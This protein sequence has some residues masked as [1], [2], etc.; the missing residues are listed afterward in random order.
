MFCKYCGNKLKDNAKFCSQC[1][2]KT[3][4]TQ[5]PVDFNDP[6]ETTIRIHIGKKAV[7]SI[8]LVF[9]VILGV[10][11]ANN[12][13]SLEDKL[14]KNTWWSEPQFHND[15]Y[16]YSDSSWYKEEHPD[17]PVVGYYVTG[18]CESLVFCEYGTIRKDK[19]NSPGD[20]GGAYTSSNK[21]TADN[22]P[23]SYRWLM[24]SDN[25]ETWTLLDGK[26]LS[27]G[28]KV[29]RWDS[30]ESESTWYMTSTTLRIGEDSYTKEKPRIYNVP[31]PPPYWCAH[32][33]EAGPFKSKC[34][35]CD[36]TEKV[37][38]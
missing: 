9:A 20:S 5:S 3:D 10:V 19:Y 8:I 12:L 11:I 38:E 26:K 30:Y 14:M 29:Y 32:C 16:D 13:P 22:F 28:E 24:Y 23:S 36:K 7:I 2:H 1:G 37:D 18:Y 27:V 34:P 31:D 25:K 21:I 33:G 4:D 6:Q 17:S 35:T 15:D